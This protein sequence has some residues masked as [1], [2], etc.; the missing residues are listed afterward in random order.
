MKTRL[1]LIISL[2]ALFSVISCGPESQMLK[3]ETAVT[4]LRNSNNDAEKM[5]KKELTDEDKTEINK[6][7]SFAQ[8]R[9]QQKRTRDMV[10]HINQI[11]DIDPDFSHARDILLFWR[12]NGYEEL[13]IKDSAIVDYERFSKMR[14]D[15][16]QVLVLLDYMYI[17]DNNLPK[18][19]DIVNRMIENDSEDKSLLR[20]LGR[21]YFQHA[22]NIK[23]D[24][25]NDPEIEEYAM[26]AIDVLEEYA[27][28][29]PE[30]EEINNLLTFL[31][32]RFLDRE[33][34]KQRLETNLSINPDDA[35]TIE[36]LA[37]IYFD[38]GDNDRAA[39]LLERYLEKHPDDL[40]T[41]RRLIRIYRND[42]TK[43]IHYNQRAIRLDPSNETYHV[44]L[45]RY[46]TERK[47]FEQARAE[48]ARAISKN[49][50]N[51]TIY[52]TWA[53]IYTES[54]SAC[55]VDIEYQDK[56]VFTIAFGLLEKAGETRRLHGMR[57]S[58]QVPSRSDYF[59]NRSVRLPSR[60][61]YRWI[62]PEWDEVK[63][64]EEFLKTL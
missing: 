39:D 10:E 59:I 50:R 45:A 17:T 7:S 47:Q 43:G 58:G 51:M 62:N 33:A 5:E 36:R 52:R 31:T 13:G 57:E 11:F 46:Y 4:E 23:E 21:Y 8:T 32:S 16:A 55:N 61:C 6:L 1:I 44:N 53:T 38:E 26:L 12:G 15:H 28:H 35:K 20:K 40:R 49:P 60:E 37:A 56:L 30:D 9:R 54:I 41:I 2:T 63:Y 18:A 29:D 22:E 25:P 3:D 19:I 27:E 14:P 24:D 34:F 42:L 64:I 48:C